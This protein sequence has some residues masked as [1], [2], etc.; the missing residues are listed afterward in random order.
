ML[1]TFVHKHSR[2]VVYSIAMVDSACKELPMYQGG[3]V[4]GATTT[5]TGAAGILM[6]PNT[7]G[8]RPL[9]V[10]AAI[11]LTMGL[12]TLIVATIAVIKQRLQA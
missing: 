7:G 12:L 3:I 2:I 10:M 4:L 9:F 6:L 1:F 5:T 8:Y 11:S